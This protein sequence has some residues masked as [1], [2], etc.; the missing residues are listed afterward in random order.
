LPGSIL[1]KLLVDAVGDGQ[2]QGPL[3]GANQVVALDEDIGGT[4]FRLG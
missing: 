4:L 1:A 3:L 2:Q